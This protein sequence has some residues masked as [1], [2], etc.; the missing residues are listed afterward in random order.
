VRGVRQA[1]ETEV[2][3]W[4]IKGNGWRDPAHLRAPLPSLAMAAAIR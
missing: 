3:A 1:K 4:C 2:L